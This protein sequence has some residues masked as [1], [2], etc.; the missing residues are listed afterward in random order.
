LNYVLDNAFRVLGLPVNATG[1]QIASRY[2]ELVAHR[3]IG[4]CPTFDQ[5]FPCLGRLDRSEESLRLAFQELQN[6]ASKWKHVAF[7]FWS[8]DGVDALAFDAL[9][10]G[11]KGKE[12]A[13]LCAP[14]R[15]YYLDI[16]FPYVVQSKFPWSLNFV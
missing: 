16:M 11:R 6:P 7:W 2:D 13:R 15:L 10:A 9:R 3:L 8:R 4:T 14:R 5:D 1:R 12:M